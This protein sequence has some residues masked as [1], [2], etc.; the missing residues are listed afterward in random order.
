MIH[1]TLCFDEGTGNQVMTGGFLTDKEASSGWMFKLSE[2]AH[3]STFDIG[4]RS[5]SS[6][7]HIL[8]YDRRKKRLVE[9]I[10]DRKI[11]LSMRAIYQSKFGLGLMDNGMLLT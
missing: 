11:V 7:S 2:W 6:A 10:I 8:V 3:F 9:E 4:L 1:M 5:G